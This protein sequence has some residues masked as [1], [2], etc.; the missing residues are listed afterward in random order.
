MQYQKLQT[1]GA[2]SDFSITD[3]DIDEKFDALRNVSD[4]DEAWILGVV[5]ITDI[6]YRYAAIAGPDGQY[7]KWFRIPLTGKTCE[8]NF[9]A[10]FANGGWKAILARPKA[11]SAFN[12]R[13]A[14]APNEFGAATGT[15]FFAITPDDGFAGG[16]IGI[17]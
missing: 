2:Y 7:G 3:G 8:T 14:T 6:A 15:E 17:S 10:C 11:S 12:I 9:D 4:A 16:L 5:N 13:I 1:K